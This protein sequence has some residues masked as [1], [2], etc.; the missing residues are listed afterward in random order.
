[1]AGQP[2]LE[3]LQRRA[4]ICRLESSFD[5]LNRPVTMC[6]AVPLDDKQNLRYSR[7]L[8]NSSI[9]KE[10]LRSPSLLVP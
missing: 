8:V 7:M 2:D 5:S 6:R 3:M 1:M 4:G 9:T 10:M